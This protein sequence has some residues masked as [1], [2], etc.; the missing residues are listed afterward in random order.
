MEIQKQSVFLCSSTI[1]EL[2][3]FDAWEWS[4]SV[5]DKNTRQE[6]GAAGRVKI[7]IK[8]KTEKKEHSRII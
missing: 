8:N 1:S 5:F 3:L 2:L 7:T 4:C 6:M